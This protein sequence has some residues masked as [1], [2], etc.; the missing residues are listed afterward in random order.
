MNEACE[1]AGKG[2]IFQMKVLRQVKEL[3]MITQ[4]ASGSPEIYMQEVQRQGLCSALLCCTALHAAVQ[5][6]LAE[7]KQKL[8]AIG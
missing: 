7:S 4:L 8:L 3:L 5:D 6:I 2:F 1:G